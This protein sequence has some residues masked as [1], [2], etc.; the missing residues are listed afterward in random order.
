MERFLC[1]NLYVSKDHFLSY[2]QIFS[3]EV[4]IYGSFT[5]KNLKRFMAPAITQFM[6]W[7]ELI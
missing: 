1:D 7:M 3:M 6:R 5:G 4:L 2:I